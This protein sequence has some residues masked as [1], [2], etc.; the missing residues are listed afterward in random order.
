MP[1]L[2]DYF[3]PSPSTADPASTGGGLLD[4]P[5]GQPTPGGLLWNYIKKSVP[6]QLGSAGQMAAGV[7]APF[8]HLFGNGG[9]EF[10]HGPQDPLAASDMR[11]ALMTLMAGGG[12]GLAAKAISGEAPALAEPL[13]ARVYRGSPIGE[14]WAPE[15]ALRNTTFWS[16]DNPEVAGWYA[17]DRGVGPNVVPA[18]VSFKN[19]LVVD[20]GGREWASIPWGRGTTAT[21]TLANLARK[22]GHDGLVVRN[23]RDVGGG[24]PLATTYAALRPGTVFSPLTGE[25]L[26]ANGSG[27]PG[28]LG[29]SSDTQRGRA[30]Q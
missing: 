22:F 30:P 15:G 13:T 16:S 8:A 1:G 2:L 9:Q 18:D 14:T 28:L 26:Y 7:A 25:R 3:N 12:D 4:A 24:G 27:L 20:A 19:P 23:V 29:M 21:D 5:D 17:G 10:W 6:S 11:N